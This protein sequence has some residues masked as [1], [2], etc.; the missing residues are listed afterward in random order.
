MPSGQILSGLIQKVS[1]EIK[2]VSPSL[3]FSCNAA[4][5]SKLVGCFAALLRQW[6]LRVIIIGLKFLTLIT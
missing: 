4:I 5:A 1:K 6:N 3:N 2:A